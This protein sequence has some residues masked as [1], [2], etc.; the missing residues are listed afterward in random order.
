MT[1]DLTK[2]T[3]IFVLDRSGSMQGKLE[4]TLESFN[5]YTQ[6]LRQ[7]E[8]DIEFTLMQFDTISTDVIHRRK[9]VREVPDLTREIYSPRGGTP[10]IDAACIAIESAKSD[11]KPS[12]KVVITIMT[13]GLENASQAFTMKDLHEKIKEVSGWGWQF[14]FL[15][16]SIDNYETGRRMGVGVGQTMSY[17]AKDLGSTQAAYAATAQSTR[18]FFE[19]G[20]AMSF[21]DIDK[22]AAGDA[23][24]KRWSDE[25]EKQG[26][27]IKQGESLVDKVKL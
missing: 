19:T 21:S 17:N 8:K 7:S 14:V 5:A 18:A 6:S 2:H 27:K 11:Y 12:D 3:V 20:E 10:L 4:S 15:G 24:A 23:Y 22:Q 13:D 9:P 25:K 1:D 16:A 26:D